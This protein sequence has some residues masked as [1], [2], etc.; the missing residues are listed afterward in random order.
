MN[1]PLNKAEERALIDFVDRSVTCTTN[2]E[3]AAKM[4]DVTKTKEDGIKIIEIV[5]ACQIHHHTKS[6]KKRG[7]TGTCRFRFPKFPI[8][9]TIL[10]KGQVDDN[11]EEAKKERIE[12][13]KALLE[14][15]MNVLEESDIVDDIMKDY[16]KNDESIEEY[17]INR[18][19][20]I[21]KILEIANVEP[22]DYLTAL[23]ESS[24]K[25]IN[26]ILARDI[27]ELYVNNY[28]PEWI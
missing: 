9:E 26:V 20:R 7:C 19:E 3:L 6:C 18:K 25:G 8:W 27:D 1:K 28:N 10:T 12:R 4:I 2:P 24:R 23:R 13:Q 16:N 5:K 11:D 21:L 17:R 14:S 22:E 15:V